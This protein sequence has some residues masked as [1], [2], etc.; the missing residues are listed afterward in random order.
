VRGDRVGRAV[1]DHPPAELALRTDELMTIGAMLLVGGSWNLSLYVQVV[2]I[3]LVFVA[4]FY[5]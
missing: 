5:I 1:L 4:V 3:G 2:V